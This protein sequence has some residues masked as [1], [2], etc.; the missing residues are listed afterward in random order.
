MAAGE[1]LPG[2]RASETGEAIGI[3]RNRREQE[4]AQQAERE[5]E[6]LRKWEED[7]RRREDDMRKRDKP[8]D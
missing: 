2:K 6:L 8:E 4:V 7:L 1:R 3:A 5:R